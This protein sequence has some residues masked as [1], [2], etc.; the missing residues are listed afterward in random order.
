MA[1][2]SISI[3]QCCSYS[4]LPAITIDSLIYTHIKV[5]GYNG[6]QFVEWFEGLPQVMNP[7]PAPH[8]VLILDNCRIHHVD[9]VQEMCDAKFVTYYLRR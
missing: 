1:L 5:G 7:Y 3:I 9:E 8:S 2:A 4:L 6:E